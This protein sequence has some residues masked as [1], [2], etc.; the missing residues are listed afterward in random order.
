[1]SKGRRESEFVRSI[2][3]VF[4]FVQR[5]L[6]VRYR[7]S[8]LGYVWSMVNP[9]LYMTILTFVF[10][11]VMSVK[12]E[13]YSMYI[14]SGMLCWNLFHQSLA[15][16]VNSLVSSGALL[17][18]VKVS[19]IL[20]P[21]AAECSV[22]VNF[23]LALIPY[24]IIGFF[25]GLNF[26]GWFFLLPLILIPYLIFIFGVALSVACLNVF[27]RDVGHTIDSI[28]TII[29]YATPIIY[30]TST[31]PEKYQLILSFN[32][33][34]HYL[35]L[36]RDV[37][38]LGRAPSLNHLAYALVFSSISLFIGL[39]IYAKTRDKIVFKI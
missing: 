38:F 27:F 16:G 6:R 29:F 7:G 3:L 28:L 14:L 33:I 17:K 18:K 39:F 4:L 20:F 11:H 25:T 23:F 1:M 37:M 12:V 19:A 31:L 2:R 9:L 32:P 10:K 22:L 5:D 13:N 8:I 24:L 26:T 35:A 30:Q 15:I 21:A 34:S 36:I